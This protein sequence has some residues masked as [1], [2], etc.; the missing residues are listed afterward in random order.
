[1]IVP[2]IAKILVESGAM[3]QMNRL[4]AEERIKFQTLV[5][6]AV[7]HFEDYFVRL[8][9]MS[10]EPAI[11]VCD[12]GTLDVRAYM[13]T[14]EF[15]CM[16]DDEGWTVNQLRDRRYDEVVYLVTA[17]DGADEFYSLSNNVARHETAEEARALDGRT[18]AAWSGHSNL[19]I[20]RNNRGE[21]FEDKMDKVIS[22]VERI[23]GHKEP[24]K[25]V[26]KYLLS[27][28]VF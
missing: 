22:L 6:K 10:G 8:A 26:E 13:T 4:S 1:M 21:T 24:C 3:I 20:L 25:R 12:R 16:I 5:V 7:V 28:G 9:E 2:E 11:V 27:K 17:A 14:E 18:L 23:V 15:E 19:T